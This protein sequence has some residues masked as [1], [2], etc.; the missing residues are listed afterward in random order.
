MGLD[1]RLGA[2]AVDSRP[3]TVVSQRPGRKKYDK[4]DMIITVARPTRP[5]GRYTV[6][7]D[8]KDNKGK[9][10]GRG[11][12]TLYID[13]AREHGTYQS[14]QQKL[15]IGDVPFKFDLGGGV[16]IKAASVAYRKK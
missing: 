3:E 16:E 14:L 7:W 10:L 8:G 12:Y 15:A 11:E 5:P 13:A 1:G 2:L 4:T 6:I 9:P